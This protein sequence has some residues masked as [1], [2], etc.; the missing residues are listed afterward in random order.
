MYIRAH[1][2]PGLPSPGRSS[3]QQQLQQRSLLW[4]K[5]IPQ[6]RRRP[7]P[8]ALRHASTAAYSH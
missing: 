7:G 3:L 1:Q 6:Q 4:R 2:R 8:A 5:P